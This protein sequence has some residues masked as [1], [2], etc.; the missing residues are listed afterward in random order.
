M[1]NKDLRELTATK[2]TATGTNAVRKLRDEKLIPGVL[3][4]HELENV[5]IQIHE[6]D[7]D[8]FFRV[9]GIGTGL[10][11]NVDGEKTF[12]L[13]KDVQ[14]NRMKNETTH[15]EFQA[16]AKG[17][18]VRLR[19]PI[20]YVGI[21]SIPVGTIFQPLHHEV[22]M[23]VLPKDLLEE[24]IVDVSETRLGDQ[25]FMS[26]LEVFK[27][28]AYDIVDDADTLLYVLSEPSLH[29]EPTEEETAEV[30]EIGK[31]V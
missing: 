27:N 3:Y 10:Q 8:K 12:V 14:L 29:V 23:T 5:N 22:E 2:R 7:F 30:P 6:Q 25:G 16:L 18:K 13:F 15:V 20:Y 21:D 26:D 17:K 9:H 24:I 11:L 28:E 19:V 4:G 31:E 1:S